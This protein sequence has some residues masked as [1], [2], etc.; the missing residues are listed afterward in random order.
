MSEIAS[1]MQYWIH[2]HQHKGK[3]IED[4]LIDQGWVYSQAPDVALFD[5]ARNKPIERRFRR[6]GATLVTYPHTAI[7]GWWYDGILEPP[8][9]FSAILAIGE[10][11][12][13]V[14]K[15][16]TPN[17]RIETIGWSYCPILPFQKP[18]A[19]NRILFAPIHPNGNR[20]R[21][22]AKDTNAR[23]YKRLLSL[24]DAEIVVR[25]LGNLDDNGLW[26]SSRA[27]IK[28]G[29]PDGSY[30]D[31][32]AA[33][34][35]VA[36]GMYL[37]LAVARGKPSIGM[38][39]HVTQKVNQNGRVPKR[40]DEYNSL[41]AYP[42]DFDDADLPELIDKAL[43]ESRVSEWKQRFIGQQLQPEYLSDLLKDIRSEH[44]R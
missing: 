37:S 42:I 23:V 5:I 10:G 2:H 18:K 44:A 17:I 8:N 1:P 11:Q 24:P 4:A 16:I 39:Q 6:G 26:Q 13:E 19:V 12:K 32:D 9:G 22:E 40:W 29:N 3:P 31:I 41:Q 7:A 33:D 25:V 20:L 36:E 14:Q 28:G 43:D 34:L 21:Q 38:N 15:I 27:I 30:E 35:V